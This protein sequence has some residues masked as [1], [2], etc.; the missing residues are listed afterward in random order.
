V[1]ILDTNVLSAL[2]E[3][4]PDEFVARWLDGQP[5]SA[6]WTTAVTLF[7]IEFGLRIMP[8]GGRQASLRRDYQRCVDEVFEGRIA[9]FD[10]AAAEETA[11][12]AARRRREGRP[13]DLRD[14]MIAGIAVARGATLATHN[15]RH[16]ADLSV[17]VVD[18]RQA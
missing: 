4:A 18:P 2:M 16:F 6:I 3:D 14:S 8:A 13:H 12:L 7:E 10:A 11:I 9:H 1:I 5:R 15:I 17:P